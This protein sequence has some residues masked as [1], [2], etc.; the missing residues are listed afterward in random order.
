[1][2]PETLTPSS[3]PV[4]GDQETIVPVDGN[5]RGPVVDANVTEDGVNV[6]EQ[7][8]P[9]ERT[10]EDTVRKPLLLWALG[11]AGSSK[12][13]GKERPPLKGRVMFWRYRFACRSEIVS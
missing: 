7:T 8:T 13:G 11:L 9:F 12:R 3:P 1:M 10:S 6:N 2:S 4:V 5:P